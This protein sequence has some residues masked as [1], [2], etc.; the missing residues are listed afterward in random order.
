M[1]VWRGASADLTLGAVVL[2][3]A[4]FL[5]SLVHRKPMRELIFESLCCLVESVR[6][7]CFWHVG[8]LTV[9]CQLSAA[10]L[11]QVVPLLVPLF[12]REVPPQPIKKHKKKTQQQEEPKAVRWSAETIGLAVTLLRVWEVPLVPKETHSV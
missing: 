6:A 1:A 11:Q 7:T 9:S 12:P 3:Q 10:Q 8:E 2:D 4:R 5:L